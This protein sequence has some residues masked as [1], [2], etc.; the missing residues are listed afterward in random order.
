MKI[1][2]ECLVMPTNGCTQTEMHGTHTL[3]GCARRK[4]QSKQSMNVDQC[5]ISPHFLRHAVHIYK[6]ANMQ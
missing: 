5:H 6:T 3:K 4:V 1:L 2:E